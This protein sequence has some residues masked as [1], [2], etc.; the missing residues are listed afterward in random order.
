MLWRFWK[1]RV[2]KISKIDNIHFGF[3]SRRGKADAIFIVQE[4]R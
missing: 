3:M 1:V 4:L 2:R